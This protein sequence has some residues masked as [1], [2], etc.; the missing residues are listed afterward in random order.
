[1]SRRSW[2]NLLLVSGLMTL[3]SST[4]HMMHVIP[5]WML[6]FSIGVNL[7]VLVINIFK[8]CRKDPW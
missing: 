5:D 8:M 2:N 4:I 7:S 6:Y 1:M 3:F